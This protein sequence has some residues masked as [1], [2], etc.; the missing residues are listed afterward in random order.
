[1]PKGFRW[2]PKLLVKKLK[3]VQRTTRLR[4][5]KKLNYSDKWVA[6]FGR[7]ETRVPLQVVSVGGTSRGIGFGHLD[8]APARLIFNQKGFHELKAN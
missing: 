8:A 5:Y 1:L 4:T 3:D 6:I 2:D 7:F